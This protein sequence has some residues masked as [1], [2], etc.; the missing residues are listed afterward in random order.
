MPPR[1][2]G[3]RGPGAKSRAT[4]SSSVADRLREKQAEKEK[5]EAEEA[6][7]K[8]AALD[9]ELEE[10]ARK[11][12]ELDADLASGTHFNARES[13]SYK[14]AVDAKKTRSM[15]QQSL[16]TLSVV[17]ALDAPR[18]R[19]PLLRPPRRLL[20]LMCPGARWWMRH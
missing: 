20:A 4:G 5:A 7:A 9:A 8:Q 12:A 15:L 3:R 11:E 13:M 19:N 2:S 16:T 1:G 10:W 18:R 14:A 17:S 6:A